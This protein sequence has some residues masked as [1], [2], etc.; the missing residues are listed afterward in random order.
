[1][2]IVSQDSGDW[3]LNRDTI[4]YNESIKNEDLRL[5]RYYLEGPMA[6]P[7]GAGVVG[8]DPPRVAEQPTEDKPLPSTAVAAKQWL[9][10]ALRYLDVVDLAR[11]CVV[12]PAWRGES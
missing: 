7:T 4:K 6:G 10:C 12:C 11:A 9:G 8:T 2:Q 3:S 5:L 1:M